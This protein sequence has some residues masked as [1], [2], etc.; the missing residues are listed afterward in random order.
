MERHVILFGVD[1]YAEGSG[2]KP[3]ACPLNDIAKLEELYSAPEHGGDPARVYKYE[4][5]THHAAEKH[6][7]EFLGDLGK[8]DTAV[9]HFSGHGMQD[10]S[11]DLHLC[12]TDTD[13]DKLMISALGTK[14]LRQIL[15]TQ[16]ARRVLITLDCCYSGA[17][18]D[19]L[20]R[21]D[22]SSQLRQLEIKGTSGNG[23]YVLS[24]SG[25]T[26]T[27]KESKELGTGIFTHHL[28][29]GIR[30]G[31][32]DRDCDGNI[33][34]SEIAEYLQN[35][36]PKDAAGQSPHLTVH[37]VS[38]S[39]VVARNHAVIIQKKVAE[40][41]SRVRGLV[42]DRTLGFKFAGELEE[43]LKEAAPTAASDDPRWGLFDQL[44]AKSI[45][46]G[47]FQVAWGNLAADWEAE[48]HQNKTGGWRLGRRKGNEGAHGGSPDTSESTKSQSRRESVKIQNE[49]SAPGWL[50][51]SSRL[52]ALLLLIQLTHFWFALDLINSVLEA[53]FHTGEVAYVLYD[54][55]SYYLLIYF[56][57]EYTFSSWQFFNLN[58]IIY[59]MNSIISL[60]VLLRVR[61][62]TE[63]R[64]TVV[65]ACILSICMLP[66]VP[67]S[68][69]AS[70]WAF[71]LDLYV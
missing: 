3:L 15:D 2:L 37:K 10:H 34:V 29:D 53:P 59:V 13:I 40:Y 68:A 26:E 11:G 62:L 33:T 14:R 47:D 63:F 51:W 17:A 50:R 55:N 61:L 6:L 1:E 30:T 31:K 35:E 27:A 24:A 32:A 64:R 41:E 65:A 9:I 39:F 7:F 43:W 28:I 16:L 54:I 42:S 69:F 20:T 45:S 48:V 46:G 44:M 71:A 21:G 4:N 67:S 70:I 19:Q 57:G 18:G 22:V 60:I 5:I 8:E 58:I 66:L 38:G 56:I 25:E 52:V 12:F 23:I 36:V 49:Q